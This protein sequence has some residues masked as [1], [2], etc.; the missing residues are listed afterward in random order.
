MN[1]PQKQLV[2]NLL[3]YVAQRD[4]SVE[5]LCK[6][7]GIDLTRLKGEDPV[8]FK[9]KQLEKLW[10]TASQFTEDPLLGLHFGEAMQ[11]AALGIVGEIIKS[12]RTVGE[13]LQQAAS[14]C[15]LVT[16]L[17][18]LEIHPSPKYF[19]IRFIP[20]PLADKSSFAFRQ[21]M[22]FFMVFMLHELDGLLLKKINPSAVY[23]PH[24]SG[25]PKEY[26]RVLRCAPQQKA[27]EY[28]MMVDHSYWEEPILTANYEIQTFLLQKV[29]EE[30]QKKTQSAS[31]RS[32]IYEHL[33]SNS[34]LELAS[35]EQVAANFNMSSRNLQR[36][37]KN[38]GVSYQQLADK[39]RKS[40]SLYYLESGNYQ[41]KEISYLLGYNELSAFT[42]AFKRWTGDTPGNYAS[43]K[44]YSKN[45]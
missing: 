31:F 41:I 45:A 20:H 23:I 29:S 24:S 13:A 16:D 8:E 34:Y 17:F 40:L 35:L 32:K 43:K 25:H 26:E 3:A 37:L 22:D 4:V 36:K 5:H 38:E 2:L 12:S 44:T 11:L 18:H 19:S 7:T 10:S 42:R 1:K 21:T 6:Q 14:L 15:Y 30:R 27:N 28:S 39:V 9:P 33:M